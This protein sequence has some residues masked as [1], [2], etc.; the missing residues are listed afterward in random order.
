MTHIY[1]T[2]P[3]LVKAWISIHKHGLLNDIITHPNNNF[4]DG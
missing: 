2:G 1:D 3:R 4:D